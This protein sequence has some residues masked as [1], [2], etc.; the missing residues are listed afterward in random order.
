MAERT[1]AA[2][3]VATLPSK[4]RCG[5][6]LSPDRRVKRVYVEDASGEEILVSIDIDA[7]AT[8]ADVRRAVAKEARNVTDTVVRGPRPVH[9]PVHTKHHAR[10]GRGSKACGRRSSAQ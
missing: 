1:R 3:V 2:V 9:T 7:C 4:Y 6:T 5:S 8:L 10:L